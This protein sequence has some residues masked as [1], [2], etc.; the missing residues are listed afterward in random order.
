MDETGLASLSKQGA[1]R[2]NNTLLVRGKEGS[3]SLHDCQGKAAEL[4]LQ[5]Q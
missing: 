1:G 3:V 5:H 4:R 2:C